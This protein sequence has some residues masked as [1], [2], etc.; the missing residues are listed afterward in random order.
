[1]STFHVLFKAQGPTLMY[2]VSI[3]PRWTIS[4]A[5]GHRLSLRLPDL[6]DQPRDHGSLSSS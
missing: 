4:D 1:M 3:E 6:L 5:D 2:K